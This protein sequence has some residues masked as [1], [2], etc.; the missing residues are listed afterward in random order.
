MANLEHLDILKQGVQI[1][2]QW[3]KEHSDILPDFSHT[4]FDGE[5]LDEAHFHKANTGVHLSLLSEAH[6]NEADLHNANLKDATFADIE[7]IN[8]DLRGANLSSSYFIRV[9]LQNANF[10]NA[11]LFNA[12]FYDETDLSYANFSNANLVRVR[13][14]R[15]DLSNSNFHRAILGDTVFNSTDL[16]M[17]KGLKTVKHISSSIIGFD[18]LIQSQ[19]DIPE[20]FLRGTGLSDTFII[21][22]HSLIGKPIDYYTCF[23]SYSSKDEAFAKR[24]YINLQSNGVRCWFAPEDLKIGDKFR[25]RIDESIR[26]YDKLLLV[27]SKHSLASTW[28]GYE[29]EKALN[30]EPE[31][32]PNV[33][34]P[35]RLDKAILTCETDWAKDIRR[36]RHIGDFEHWKDH[37]AYQIAFQRLLRDLKAQA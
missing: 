19:G 3:R 35:I 13:F 8:I 1:W 25:H 12:M 20:V 31:G 9:N 29:V 26:L 23:I 30:K 10:S 22:T 33:L 21:Y 11:N 34:F 4:H 15:T 27:L 5:D 36:S 14:I 37:D 17:T 24:L 6:L 16:H 28:V 7:L 2:N 18:T 32:V